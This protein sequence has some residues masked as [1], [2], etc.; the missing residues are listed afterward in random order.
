MPL[1]AH[2]DG[3]NMD[4]YRVSNLSYVWIHIEVVVGDMDK[5]LVLWPGGAH[6][7]RIGG[8]DS[9]SDRLSNR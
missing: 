7:P 2:H 4:Q 1:H 6:D 5:V 3:S 9:T 8:A